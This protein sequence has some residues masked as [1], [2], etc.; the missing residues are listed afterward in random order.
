MDRWF[1]FR[2]AACVGLLWALWV[3]APAAAQDAGAPT[4]QLELRPAAVL[5]VMRPSAGAD[6]S[7][8]EVLTRSI[9]VKLTRR[10]LRAITD[11]ATALV[12]SGSEGS[13]SLFSLARQ[14]EADYVLE[15]TYSNTRDEI[16]IQVVWY[17]ALTRQAAVSVSERGRL[18]LNVDSLL[19]QALSAVFAQVDGELARYSTAAVTEVLGSGGGFTEQRSEDGSAAATVSLGGLPVP[20]GGGSGLPAPA[21]PAPEQASPRLRPDLAPG[22]ILEPDRPTGGE[23][24]G[25]R[26][27]VE[28]AASG[29]AF[30]ATGEAS[31]YFKIGYGS[32]V[33]VDLLLTAGQGSFGLGLYAAVNYFEAIGVA[34]SAQSLLVPMGADLRYTMDE[35]LPLGLF[36]HVSGG[37]AMLVLAS[38]Y[39]GQLTKLVPYALAGLGMN[40]RF[41]PAM[42]TAL[43]LSYSVYFEGSLLIMAFS[44][45]LSLYFRF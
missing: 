15:G 29:A 8:Q 44:P 11:P 12:S 10:G 45:S 16:E 7:L 34:T 20:S 41:A 17:D 32:A 22:E 37:P 36:V 28:V 23:E 30:I 6:G 9:A 26:K 25:R 31:E 19:A 39:W 4:E 43:D 35:G 3:T 5:G 42:G 21:A 1:G 2:L 24:R 18:G 38:D 13:E 33:Y 27:H 14:V 40:L